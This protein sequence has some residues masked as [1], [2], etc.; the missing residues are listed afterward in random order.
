MKC[1]LSKIALLAGVMILTAGTAHAVN[2]TIPDKESEGTGWYSDREDQEVE[3][4][5]IA[6]QVWDLEGFYLDGNKL[7]MVGGYNFSNPPAGGLQGDIF[8]D[9]DG[10]AQFGHGNINAGLTYPNNTTSNVF[11]YDYVID[12]NF[13]ANNYQVYEI[14][15]QSQVRTAYYSQ[16]YE[17]N[18]WQYV[19]R[20]TPI[21]GLG[22]ISFG[23]AGIDTSGLLGGGTHYGVSV[24]LGFLDPNT[25][26]ISHYTMQCGNDNLMGRGTTAVPE[27]GTLLLLGAGLVGLAGF[28]RRKRN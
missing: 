11:G 1:K 12:L 7:T 21:G 27:P 5:C 28:R 18:P 16:N 15:A 3:P 26:F 17:S 19:S 13:G 14:N 20:G 10:N 25:T 24:D 4:G 23:T 9:V 6:T 8:I 22:V 2:I